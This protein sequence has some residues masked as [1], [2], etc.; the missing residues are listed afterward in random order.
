MAY[1]RKEDQARA[2]AK[3]YEENK[4]A[5]KERSKIRNRAQR[6]KNKDFVDRVKR[7]F[8]CVDCGESNPIVLEFDHVIG[9]KVGNVS[10]MCR[11]S[12]STSTIKNEIRK[13]EIRCAN[14]HRKKTHER[15]H[16]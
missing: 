13:C 2:S 15:M 1:K 14:C 7:I 9:D 16:L 6:K 10:D 3:H 11:K 4:A 8:D 12:Y 5:I